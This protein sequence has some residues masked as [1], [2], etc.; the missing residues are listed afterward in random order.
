[1]KYDELRKP[2][3]WGIFSWQDCRSNCVQAKPHIQNFKILTTK[4]LK[5][6]QEDTSASS[7]DATVEII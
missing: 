4:S 7:A 5:F 3:S 2:Q 1:M 6:F